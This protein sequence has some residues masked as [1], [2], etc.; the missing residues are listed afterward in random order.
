MRSP[1]LAV[2]AAWGRPCA[3]GSR[4]LDMQVAG[5]RRMLRGLCGAGRGQAVRIRALRGVGYALE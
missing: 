3:A 1:G 4:A 5:L 2:T